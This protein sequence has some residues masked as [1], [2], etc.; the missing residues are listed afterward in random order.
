MLFNKL[1]VALRYSVLR[2]DNNFRNGTTRISN[3]RPIQEVVPGLSYY[4]KGHDHKLVLD[5]PVLIN[6]PTFIENYAGNKDGV[7]VGTEQP[8]QV[9]V[10]SG[11][12]G[13][14]EYQT[15]TEARL[16]YQ[17]AF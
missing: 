12:K 17:L 8:D 6:V 7:Y 10:I 2:L 3:G 4:I 9:S 13:R 16:M 1:E 14:L 15:V 11:G 5:F